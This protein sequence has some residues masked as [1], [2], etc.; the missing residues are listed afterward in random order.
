[1]GYYIRRK[2]D[3]ILEVEASGVNVV[4]LTKE[5]AIVKEMDELESGIDQAWVDSVADRKVDANAALS[6]FRKN[7][8]ELSQ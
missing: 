8:S 4:Y 5:D 2:Q 1:M 3:G 6:F 7:V